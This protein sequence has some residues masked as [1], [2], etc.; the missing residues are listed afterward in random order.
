MKV[1]SGR[2]AE[3]ELFHESNV[4]TQEESRMSE[5]RNLI[6]CFNGQRRWYER[7]KGRKDKGR[8][9]KIRK[10][11]SSLNFDDLCTIQL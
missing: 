11:Y 6:H 1:R 10:K 8:R 4:V 3:K 2:V 5:E 7:Q 9:M